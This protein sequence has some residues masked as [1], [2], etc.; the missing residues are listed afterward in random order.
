MHVCVLV[1]H[2]QPFHWISC[3]HLEMSIELPNLVSNSLLELVGAQ[4]SI[5]CEAYPW[6][7]FF[8]DIV[9][10]YFSVD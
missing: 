3:R 8:A 5:L 2:V 7:V 1:H 6:E 4:Q 9:V 10:G